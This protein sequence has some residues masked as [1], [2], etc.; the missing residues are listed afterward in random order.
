MP[1]F[2]QDDMLSVSSPYSYDC[3]VKGKTETRWAFEIKGAQNIEL[4]GN[5][6]NLTIKHFEEIGKRGKEIEEMKEKEA[7]E[8]KKVVKKKK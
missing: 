7:K 8:K 4:I 2:T 5:L 1:Q 3:V 6:R